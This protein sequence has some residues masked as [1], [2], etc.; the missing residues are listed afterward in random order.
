MKYAIVGTGSIGT[1]H[2][3][4]IAQLDPE[5]EFILVRSSTQPK[6]N[7]IKLKQELPGTIIEVQAIHEAGEADA[8]L[9]TNPTSMHT[10]TCLEALKYFKYIFL[11]KPFSDSMENSDEVKSMA[12]QKQASILPG[13]VLRYSTIIKKIKEL[14]PR[15]GKAYYAR[16]VSSSYL[17]DWRKGKDYRTSYSA[18]RSGGGGVILD[19][20]HEIDYVYNLFGKPEKID[21]ISGKIS[22]LDIE[23]EDIAEITLKYPGQVCS[24][25]LDYISRKPKRTFEAIG[26]KG[27][28]EAD[29]LSGK[30]IL[31]TPKGEE[32]HECKPIGNE[33]F[34]EEM[35]HFIQVIKGNEKPI[36]DIKQGLDVLSICL[37]AK[38][39]GGLR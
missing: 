39:Q 15:L 32:L 19:I 30:I 22:H 35:R 10:S 14:M 7:I 16:A 21:A 11:E 18:K 25:H 20:S 4:N 27:N 2:I 12:E 36:Q 31:I 34:I 9:I 6:E 37:E 13:Y 38:A 29:L 23:T 24:I 3:R 26:E 17:P 1:R 33:M 5:A 8:C 28:I